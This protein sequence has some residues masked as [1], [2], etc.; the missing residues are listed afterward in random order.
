MSVDPELEAMSKVYDAVQG[1]EEE[2]QQ[3]VLDWVLAKLG[4]SMTKAGKKKSLNIIESEEEISDGELESFESVADIFSAA[5]VNTESQKVL[6][7]A[8]FLQIKQGKKELIS[9]EINDELKHLGHKISNITSAINGLLNRKPQWMIQ[10]RK[11]GAHKQAQKK[12]KV[13]V[14]GFTEAKKLLANEADE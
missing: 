11:D 4:L 7:V 8:A 13:T 1:L 6:L 9:K 14:A 10:T 2:Q 3:R 12:F 5:T